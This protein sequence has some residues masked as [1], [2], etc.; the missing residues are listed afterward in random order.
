MIAEASSEILRISEGIPSPSPSLILTPSQIDKA[1]VHCLTKKPGTLSSEQVE[2][3]LKALGCCGAQ[4]LIASYPVC[5]QRLLLAA[6]RAW[7]LMSDQR[8]TIEQ[9]VL[10]NVFDNYR[11]KDVYITLLGGSSIRRFRANSLVLKQLSHHFKTLFE[12]SMREGIQLQRVWSKSHPLTKNRTVPRTP[13]VK[14]QIEVSAS[15]LKIL[16]GSSSLPR[17]PSITLWRDLEYLQ[18]T[19]KQSLLTDCLLARLTTTLS[20]ENVLD[21]YFFISEQ[22]LRGTSPILDYF[23]ESC[24]RLLIETI[25]SIEEWNAI[26]E[27]IPDHG[28]DLLLRGLQNHI[29]F[30]RFQAIPDQDL[31]ALFTDEQTATSNI[32][33]DLAADLLI[34]R[35][36]E[37]LLELFSFEEVAPLLPA[38]SPPKQKRK[39]INWIIQK[40]QLL[41]EPS[42]QVPSKSP[43]REWLEMFERVIPY[44]TRYDRLDIQGLSTEQVSWLLD[45][46]APYATS[47]NLSGFN[48]RTDASLWSRTYPVLKSLK[49]SHCVN[50]LSFNGRKRQLPKLN[51]LDLS[52]NPQLY[53]ISMVQ[54]P[55]LFRL[56]VSYCPKWTRLGFPISQSSLNWINILGCSPKIVPSI[57]QLARCRP[58]LTLISD[59]LRPTR[60]V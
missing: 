22:I 16:L 58:S 32:S 54:A 44:V 20:A 37:H 49:M 13:R 25:D 19:S 34:S 55:E 5:T 52:D 9:T 50:L 23:K 41:N 53:E 33:Y 6:Q 40:Q 8:A 35:L 15:A 51:Q 29:D 36:K 17:R 10:W 12:F 31:F 7:H 18:P 57:L 59:E 11:P 38:A 48:E 45:R 42:S 43:H 60:W 2:V 27:T 3:V 56:D 1:I 30:L 26:V 21:R 24:V 14:I 47:L 4:K 28:R 39:L 46:I